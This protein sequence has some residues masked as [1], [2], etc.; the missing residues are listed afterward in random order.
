MSVFISNHSGSLQGAEHQE[1][2]THTSVGERK[3]SQP[4]SSCFS[5]ANAGK[6][7]SHIVF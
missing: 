6:Q 5:D 2:A 7:I 3:I 4:M 1:S